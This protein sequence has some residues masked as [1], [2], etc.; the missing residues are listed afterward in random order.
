MTRSVSSLRFRAAAA[1]VPFSEPSYS[2]SNSSE[3]KTRYKISHAGRLMALAF[4]TYA[5]KQ[6]AADGDATE[7]D[8]AVSDIRKADIVLYQFETC[9]FCHKVRVFLDFHNI[10][11]RVVEVN[12]LWKTELNQ[13]SDYKK[14]PL[15]KINGREVRDSDHIIDILHGYLLREHQDA[16]FTDNEKQWRQYVNF[17]IS[18]LFTANVYQTLNDSFQMMDYINK[19]S[20][21]SAFGKASAYWFGSIA[22]YMLGRKRQKELGT[23][24]RQALYVEVDKVVKALHT[25]GKPFLSGDKPGDADVFVFSMFRALESLRTFADIRANCDIMPWFLRME[26]AVGPSKRIS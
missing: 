13:V 9:P 17:V 24:P 22:M 26:E 4:A 15:M 12:P 21:F 5:A 7:L 3:S 19:S 6:A 1:V 25:S 2:S 11:Y 23:D 10:P 8:P 18:R 20:N 14:V 16:P